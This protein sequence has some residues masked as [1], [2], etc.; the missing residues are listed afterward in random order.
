M[1]P[2]TLKS[3]RGRNAIRAPTLTSD[4]HPLAPIHSVPSSTL[5]PPPDPQEN[6]LPQET[7]RYVPFPAA[8]SAQ[9]GPLHVI[10]I[11]EASGF[12]NSQLSE[13]ST[14]VQRPAT[15]TQLA[16]GDPPTQGGLPARDDAPADHVIV[17]PIVRPESWFCHV[18]NN[19][20][21]SIV[22]CLRCVGLTAS[23]VCGHEKCHLCRTE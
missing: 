17:A 2:P 5:P 3:R 10:S 9:H 12:P 22:L 23:G 7:S 4:D 21:Q 18:C 11:E 6:P 1:C 13:P 20:P 16:L 15:G 8:E 14:I 19:G